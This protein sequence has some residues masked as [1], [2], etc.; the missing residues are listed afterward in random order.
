MRR[1]TA[2]S[3][4]AFARVET[5]PDPISFLLTR[6]SSDPYACGAYSYLANGSTPRDRKL[7]AAPADGRL[8]F[9]GEATDL[10]FPATV[11][12]A[13]LSGQR[14]AQEIIEQG[15]DSV[16]IIGAGAAGLAAA[17]NLVDAGIHVTLLEARNRIGG[18]VWTDDSWGYPLN[19]GASWVHGVNGN[20]LSAIADKINAVLV[21]TDYDCRIVRDAGGLI[22]APDDYPDDF[23]KVTAI[24]HEY[25][26]SIN[27]LAPLATYEGDSFGGGDALLP[28]GYVKLL[29]TLIGGYDIIYDIVVDM[30]IV[31]NE[32]VAVE[33]GDIFYSGDA[34]LLSVSLGVLKSGAIKF[35]PPLDSI[36]QGAI[37]RLGF[38][39]LNKLYLRFDRIFWDLNADIIGYI[40][41][42]RGYFSEWLNIAKYTGEP[43]LLGFNAATA[44]KELEAM[45]DE[46]IV[47]EAMT[48]LRGMYEIRNR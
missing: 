14:A 10:N 40:G 24:E 48:A 4:A 39:L 31:K 33:S 44:A 17:R 29:E 5:V 6:W 16:V 46:Q 34:A 26:A 23:E 35:K 1:P 2:H 21:P 45:S 12:G 27:E 8:F 3:F 20:P 18:R 15:A 28:G 22:V 7:L 36:R 43:I 13:L 47:E 9:A 11:H 38:G 30:I 32:S 41:P 19:L 37:D 42:K 25:G